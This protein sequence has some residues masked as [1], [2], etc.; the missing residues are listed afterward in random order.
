MHA[1]GGE[2]APRR[3]DRDASV[4]A[5]PD[6]AGDAALLIQYE[7][8]LRSEAVPVRGTQEAG[9]HGSVTEHAA[10]AVRGIDT[11]HAGGELV[12]DRGPDGARRAQAAAGAFGGG[13][14][15]GLAHRSTHFFPRQNMMRTRDD[16][17]VTRTAAWA[18]S[19]AR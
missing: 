16:P 9:D 2:E 12:G 4:E 11:Q 18:K 15:S 1:A 3:P 19:P 5:R 14:A 8:G 10:S 7:E 17:G 6:L 13:D